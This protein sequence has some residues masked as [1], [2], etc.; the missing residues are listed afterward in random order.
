MN[1][2]TTKILSNKSAAA[3]KAE[4]AKY[5]ETFNVKETQ[6]I[7]EEVVKKVTEDALKEWIN[8]NIDKVV[9]QSIKEELEN[10]AKK[11]L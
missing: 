4:L 11:K 10:I 7:V 1:K 8:T 9:K 3:I 6:K 2:K 5:S